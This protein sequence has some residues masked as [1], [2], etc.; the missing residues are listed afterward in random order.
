MLNVCQRFDVPT[1]HSA[2]LNE[3]DYGDY[4][5]KNKWEMEEKIGVEEFEKLRRGWDY[6]VPNGETLKMV[7]L[8]KRVF[9]FGVEL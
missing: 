7:A 6:P 5:G 8:T 9:Q 3:R 1:E 4:T 2:A